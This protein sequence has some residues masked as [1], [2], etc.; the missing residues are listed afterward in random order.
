MDFSDY[1][2][3]LIRWVA[4]SSDLNKFSS[5]IVLSG[6]W[7]FSALGCNNPA[8]QRNLLAVL[9]EMLDPFQR[10]GEIDYFSLRTVDVSNDT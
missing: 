6:Y 4:A 9:I 10:I 8:N 1:S 3:S 7:K 5:F 2:L